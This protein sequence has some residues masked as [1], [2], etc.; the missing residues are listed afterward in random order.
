MGLSIKN[1]AM[2]AGVFIVYAAIMLL[3]GAILYKRTNNLTDFVL[4]GRKLNPWTT[5]L[6]AQASDMSSW[7]LMGLPGL[8]YLGMGSTV[9]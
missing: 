3:I 7:L 4:G 8:A 1:P 2:I 5:A 6:S 9:A